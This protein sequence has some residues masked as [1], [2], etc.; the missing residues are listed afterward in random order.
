MKPKSRDSN[1]KNHDIVQLGGFD[2]A[3]D[4]PYILNIQHDPQPDNLTEFGPAPIERHLLGNASLIVRR[5]INNKQLSMANSAHTFYEI[6]FK[7][8]QRLDLKEGDIVNLVWN[9]D[10]PDNIKIRWV[11]R[12]EP[13]SLTSPAPSTKSKYK[14]SQPKDEKYT[15]T[16]NFDLNGQ[17]VGLLSADD[18][19]MSNLSKVVTAHNGK[20]TIVTLKSASI[21]KQKTKEFDI[22]ILMQSYIKHIVSQSAIA[23][24]KSADTKIAMSRSTFIGK[25]SL[26][27]K[28]QFECCRFTNNRLPT[29]RVK[30]SFLNI[31][32][33]R[34]RSYFK[35]FSLIN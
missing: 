22:I 28:Q 26:S 35:K 12:D 9:T 15:S 29:G 21:S 19:I 18:S 16:L 25:G 20:P 31:E 1:L 17:T 23:E 33:T 14:T 11:Y 2:D 3:H 7:Y 32:L 24:A 6:P 34:R 13:D 30:V 10:N 5:D 8:S 4:Q 27:C